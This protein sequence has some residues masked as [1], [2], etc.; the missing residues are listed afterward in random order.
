MG[1]S[2]EVIIGKKVKKLVGKIKKFTEKWDPLGAGT[3]NQFVDPLAD[4]WLGTDF[5]GMKALEAQN[6][7]DATARNEALLAQLSQQQ[8]A[9]NVDLGFEN[10]PDTQ[11]GGT[12]TSLS[13]SSTTKKK[14]AP[15]GVASSL[16]INV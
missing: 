6:A 1:N 5:T 4:Q 14:K 3:L 11:V 13:T 2:R 7:A 12:A 10:T 9:S 16:G 8:A 15:G